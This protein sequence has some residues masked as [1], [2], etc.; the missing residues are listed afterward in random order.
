MTAPRRRKKA[1]ATPPPTPEDALGF[2]IG[3]GR[4][5]RVVDDGAGAALS[6]L[7][8]PGGREIARVPLADRTEGALLAAVEALLAEPLSAP[9]ARERVPHAAAVDGV[10]GFVAPVRV[11]APPGFPAFDFSGLAE[12]SVREARTRVRAAIEQSGLPFP[13]RRAIRAVVE[14]PGGRPAGG[15]GYDLAL[16]VGVLVATG[17]CPDGMLGDWALLGELSLSGGLRAARGAY[18]ACLAAARAGFR[19]VVVPE[20]S[21]EEALA[22]CA[23]HGAVALCAGNLREVRDFLAGGALRRADD[24][25]RYAPPPAGRGDPPTPTLEEIMLPAE[26]KLAAEVAAAGGHHMLLVAP[27]GS[28]A[29]LLARAIRG[30]LPPPSPG[31][32]EGIAS[33]ASAAGF[34][35][36]PQRPFRAP[37]HTASAVG[38]AGGGDPPRPGELALAHGGVL[39]LEDLPE[40][41]REAMEAVRWALDEGSISIVRRDARWDFPARFHLFARTLPCP[42][43]YRG[44]NR[45]DCPAERVAR[46][47]ERGAGI[48]ERCDVRVSVG[49]SFGDPPA[50]HPPGAAG[51]VAEAWAVQHAR[52]GALNGATRDARDVSPEARRE[53]ERARPGPGARQALRVARTVADLAGSSYVLPQHVA[54]AL[55]LSEPVRGGP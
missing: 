49:S 46:Y 15:A 54:L 42:C 5:V 19:G 7:D 50:P 23:P 12:G 47:R 38:L 37:H 33:A 35:Y 8:G 24:V 53:A 44:S 39:M 51:R 13:A 31:L 17:E 9:A 55:A 34:G 22:A 30:L 28:G 1:D 52:Q 29:H 26:A 48:A 20:E 14:G 6:V 40:F 2:P 18:P 16:A 4:H 11:S 32:A 41:S 36:K 3:D 43:G 45:C 25:L 21:A 10:R 27:H